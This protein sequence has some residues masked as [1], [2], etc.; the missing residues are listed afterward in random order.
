MREIISAHE[1]LLPVIPFVMAFLA[2]CWAH[3]Q[4]VRVANVKDIV[5]KPDYRKLQSDPVPVLGGMAVF[6]GIM[7]GLGFV[8]PFVDSS[9]I[10]LILAAMTLMLYI[11]TTDDILD[12]SPRLRF[13]VEVLGVFFL[14]CVGDCC[15]DD[16]HGLWGIGRIPCWWGGAA[17]TVFAAVGI[18]NAINLIDGVNGLSSGFGVMACTVFG[19]FFF[20]AGD[21]SMVLLAAGCIGALI[22]FF[23]H[24]VFG[25]KSRMFIGDGGTLLMGMAM[26][27]FVI[28][29]LDS[30]S[31]CAPF[32]DRGLGL[33]PFTLAVL[34]VPVFDTLR[35]M[36]ARVKRRVSPFHPDKT[37]LHHLFIDLGFSHIGTTFCIL[38]L[39][40]CV[41]LCLWLLYALGFSVDVQLYGVVAMSSLVTFGLYYFVRWCAQRGNGFYRFLLRLGKVSQFER[42]GVFLAIQHFMDRM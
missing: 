30:K 3:P 21:L 19:L 17:L 27:V 37:H 15:I 34:A 29:V 23:F 5:D 10:A 41:I 32:G 36:S 40:A 6:F 28:H 31:M 4:I 25:K 24:N 9:Q 20:R 11:G 38:S 14:V 33:I 16:F 26:S 2:V 13:V 8:S 7:V 1:W 18:I 39:N 42:R 35:V 22:P 12:L